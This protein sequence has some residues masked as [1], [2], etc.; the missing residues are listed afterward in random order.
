MP[1]GHHSDNKSL[2]AIESKA[3]LKEI[4]KDCV[5]FA[6]ASGGQIRIGIEDGTH[7]PPA[8][9]RILDR[10][11]DLLRKRMRELT[12]NVESYPERRSTDSGDEYIILNIRRSNGVASTTDGKF[13]IRVGDSC[14]AIVGNQVLRLATDR[15]TESWETMTSL[16]VASDRADEDKREGFVSGIRVSDGVEQSVREKSSDELIEHYGLARDG[17]LTNLGVLLIGKAQDRARLGTAPIVQAVKYDGRGEKSAKYVWDDHSLSPV[18]LVDDIVKSIPD[19]REIYEIKDGLFRE[20]IQV[21]KR[22]VVRELIVNAL[23]HR[24]Y[25]Q[26]GDIAISLRP[27]GLE[28]TNAGRLPVGVEPARIL[29]E[30]QRRNPALARV[31]HDLKLMEREGS[32]FDFLY[33]SLLS[34]GR[35]VPTVREGTDSVVVTIER[36]V[37]YP[38]TI[39]LIAQLSER[40]SLSQRA[41]ITLALLAQSERTSAADLVERLALPNADALRSWVEGLVRNGVVVKRGRTRGI[42]YHVAPELLRG[43][44]LD[45][46]TTLARIEPH[47]LVA[48]LEEDLRRYPNSSNEEIR[49]RVGSEIPPRA[50]GRAL[51]QLVDDGV[52]VGEGQTRARRYR[53]T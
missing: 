12:V 17:V 7:A 45:T 10:Q 29:H 23:V 43:V 50:I 46:Q 19:F 27:D 33:D 3:G 36:H 32:G 9:Q 31:F 2:R 24:P 47:R 40:F 44:G 13:F 1:E 6:N 4:A 15:P 21:Y 49:Q 51:R 41:R 52:I 26:H 48:L 35:K 39:G 20:H 18:E 16:A 11:L 25:T 22:A 53:L 14:R 42:S 37:I 5:C 8:G 30:S 28:I 38:K 34:T